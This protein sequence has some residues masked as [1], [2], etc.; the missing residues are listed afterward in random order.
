MRCYDFFFYTL[1]AFLTF[2]YFFIVIFS[3][4]TEIIIFEERRDIAMRKLWFII[5][6]LI[7][8]TAI[9]RA[10]KIE[11]AK[12][13]CPHPR[14][15]AEY[16]KHVGRDLHAFLRSEM[17]TE[18]VDVYIPEMTLKADPYVNSEGFLICAYHDVH[19]HSDVP[20]LFVRMG[21]VQELETIKRPPTEIEKHKK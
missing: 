20:L 5:F 4:S 8:N 17:Q 15:V 2:S 21:K 9:G 3:R 14:L 11:P 7:L 19:K 13:V 1:N 16:F 6:C 10:E 12:I 18:I